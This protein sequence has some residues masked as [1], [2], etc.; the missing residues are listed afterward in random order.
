MLF[1]ISYA[2]KHKIQNHI[3]CR[4]SLIYLYVRRYI[5]IYKLLSNGKIILSYIVYLISFP[6]LYRNFSDVVQRASDI[7]VHSLM[8]IE[9]EK[10]IQRQKGSIDP[11]IYYN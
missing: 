11:L 4:G 2:S 5:Y 9:N 7:I 10:Q 8:E 1:E 6:F 3:I